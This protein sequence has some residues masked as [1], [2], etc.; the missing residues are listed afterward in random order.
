MDL[1]LDFANDVKPE[2]IALDQENCRRDGAPR[3]VASMRH[4]AGE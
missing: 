3:D 4:S 1:R 2:D